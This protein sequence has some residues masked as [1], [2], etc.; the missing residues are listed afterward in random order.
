MQNGI[1]KYFLVCAIAGFIS[2]IV[3]S[4]VFY[5]AYRILISIGII[6]TGTFLLFSLT[7]K[8]SNPK[9]NKK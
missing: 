7:G 9:K 5:S 2:G 6:S 4:Q 8:S 3:V 1:S